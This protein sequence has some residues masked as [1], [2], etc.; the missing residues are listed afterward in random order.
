MKNS[1]EG[2]NNR[3][4]TAKENANDF[5]DIAIESIQK[6]TENNDFKSEQSLSDLWDN[7]RKSKI[8]VIGIPE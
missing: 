7:I 2:I 4:H 3:F 5:E 8:H 1:L 6:E